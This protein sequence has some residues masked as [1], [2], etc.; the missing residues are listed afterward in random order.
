MP[1]VV[2]TR[3]WANQETRESLDLSSK[4]DLYPSGTGL[5]PYESQ[6]QLKKDGDPNKHDTTVKFNFDHPESLEQGSGPTP[7]GWRKS[8]LHKIRINVPNYNTNSAKSNLGSR[9]SKRGFS[10]SEIDGRIASALEQLFRSKSQQGRFVLEL[11]QVSLVGHIIDVKDIS[12]DVAPFLRTADGLVLVQKKPSF[13]ATR[14]I[15]RA[16][17]ESRSTTYSLPK[18]IKD[19]LSTRK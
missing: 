8:R 5:S 16:L 18:R 2:K 12:I 3:R 9:A 7:I 1:S 19:I 6:P 13:R 4:K 11:L 10:K 14:L 17:R 15:I